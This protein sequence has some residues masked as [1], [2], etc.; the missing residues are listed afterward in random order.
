LNILAELE[1]ILISGEDDLVSATTWE[2]IVAVILDKLTEVD[3][4]IVIT[5]IDQLLETSLALSFMLQNFQKTIILTSSHIS[6]RNFVDNKEII[7]ALKAKYGGLGL[8]ANLIN[9]LQI[10][11]HALPG[12]AIMFGSKLL[13][14]LKVVGQQSDSLNFFSTLDNDYWG[15]VDFGVNVKA[16][17]VTVG[18]ATHVYKKIKADILVLEDIP[19]SAWFYNKE[20]L[21]KY[22][23]IFIKVKP[24]QNLSSE[25]Q[26]QISSASKPVVLYNYQSVPNIK[27]AIAL[28]GCTATTALLK[29]MWATA[30]FSKISDF[31]S[32]MQQNVIGE[33]IN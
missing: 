25:K 32:F 28:T 10:A 16:N 1:P 22:Q 18:Q 4:F 33:F 27:N 2:K 29:T 9:A 13:S 15:K 17:L 14:P 31:R 19:G 26:K 30:N 23:A 3:G 6:G 11:D 7:N 5:K 20:Q 8:R 24:F 12:P 21:A